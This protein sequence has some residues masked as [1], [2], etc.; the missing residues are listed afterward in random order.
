[1]FRRIEIRTIA[2]SGVNLCARFETWYLQ[3]A[4]ELWLLSA[5][6]ETLVRG[7]GNR[8]RGMGYDRSVWIDKLEVIAEDEVIVVIDKPAG[9]LTMATEKEKT[10]TAYAVLRAYLNNK[11]PP[12]KLF[13]VHRLD[14]EASGLVVF[15]KSPESKERLQAQFKDHSAGRRYVA[16][17]HGRVKE[18]AFTVKSNLAENAAFR[19]YSTQNRRLGKLA[20][21][22]VKVLKR[23]SKTTLVEVRLETGRKHQIRV[24]LAERGHP[25]VGD[26]AYGSTLNPI[27]RLALH[28]VRLEFKHPVSGE[29]KTLVSNYPKE[30]NRL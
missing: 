7:G 30:F 22:H 8:K 23:N 2:D 24:H 9:L 14:R 27:R 6:P 13:I 11:K 18:D 26:K 16:V 20:V 17:V 19:V 10:R 29:H 3:G 1:M 21:T 25:I 15:A 28:G 4:I 5:L 12:E